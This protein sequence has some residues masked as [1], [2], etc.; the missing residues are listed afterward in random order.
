MVQ[1]VYEVNSLPGN[2]DSWSATVQRDVLEP[3]K[4]AQ[5]DWGSPDTKLPPAGQQVCYSEQRE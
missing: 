1:V 3:L 2:L 4:K 5:E